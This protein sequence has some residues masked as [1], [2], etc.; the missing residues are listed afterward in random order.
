MNKRPHEYSR[1]QLLKIIDTGRLVAQR[2]GAAPQN[3]REFIEMALEAFLN[4]DTEVAL[5][6]LRDGIDLYQGDDDRGSCLS[7]KFAES[8]R[9]VDQG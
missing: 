2:L 6:H 5:A 4:F 9:R 1:E 3:E 8:I 7:A